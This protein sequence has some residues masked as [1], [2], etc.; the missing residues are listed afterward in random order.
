MASQLS[1]SGTAAAAM[2]CCTD[3]VYRLLQQGFA[4]SVGRHKAASAYSKLPVHTSVLYC[5]THESVCV[6]LVKTVHLCLRF[7]AL[8]SRRVHTCRFCKAFAIGYHHFMS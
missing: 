8:A 6:A 1:L 7:N 4:L 2:Q 3:L 5:V